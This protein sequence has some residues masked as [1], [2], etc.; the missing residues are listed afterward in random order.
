MS[1]LRM[2][3]TTYIFLSYQLPTS[4][5]SPTG[6]TAFVDTLFAALRSKSYVP[7]SSTPATYDHTSAKPQDIGIPIPLDLFTS[8]LSTSPEGNR[9]RSHEDDD[10]DARGPPKGPRLG[11]DAYFNR[12]AYANGSNQSDNWQRTPMDGPRGD[13]N[14]NGV[15]PRQNGRVML[16]RGVC[17]D[18]HRMYTPTLR[19][20]N[21]HC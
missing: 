12:N 6:A 15:G 13:F 16:P 5:F 19:S 11:N 21:T 1:S 18:Y 14:T 7:Y 10:R 8:P 4:T 17:R 9:K 3:R 20:Q 2:V